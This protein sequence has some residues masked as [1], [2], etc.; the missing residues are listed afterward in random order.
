MPQL[1]LNVEQEKLTSCLCGQETGVEGRL[2]GHVRAGGGRHG[3]RGQPGRQQGES[4]VSSP[5]A[6]LLFPPVLNFLL[7]RVCRQ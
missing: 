4:G 5:P 3:V 2:H 1:F 7:C 6:A